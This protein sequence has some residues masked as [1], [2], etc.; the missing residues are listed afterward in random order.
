MMLSLYRFVSAAG[1][2]LIRLYLGLRKARGKEDPARFNERLGHPG[3][4]RPEG[5]LVWAHAASVGESLL[6]SAVGG[7]VG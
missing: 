2:P 3:K 4:A 5:P 1:V 7:T 6:P